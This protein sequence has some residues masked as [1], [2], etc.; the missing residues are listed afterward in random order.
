MAYGQLL[1]FINMYTIL[2][3]KNK[4]RILHEVTLLMLRS[5][6]FCLPLK[7]RNHNLGNHNILLSC[8]H[9]MHYHDYSLC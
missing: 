7:K 3:I 8:V 4:C 2:L 9:S 6:F 1:V 5:L